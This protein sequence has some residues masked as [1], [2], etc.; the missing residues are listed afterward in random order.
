MSALLGWAALTLAGA[1]CETRRDSAVT[2]AAATVASIPYRGYVLGVRAGDSEEVWE[3]PREFCSAVYATSAA[4]AAKVNGSPDA[5]EVADRAKDPPGL[6]YIH[7]GTRVDVV[8][9]E[10]RTC[11][12]TTTPI[13]WTRLRIRDVS[14]SLDGCTFYFRAGH[15]EKVGGDSNAGLVHRIAL[16]RTKASVSRAKGGDMPD[17]LILKGG[18]HVRIDI[19]SWPGTAEVAAVTRTLSGYKHS[20]DE[21]PDSLDLPI[22]VDATIDGIVGQAHFGD[23]YVKIHGANWSGFTR[24]DRMM[25]MVPVG[26]KLI[27]AGGAPPL[28]PNLDADDAHSLRT[29]SGTSFREI[30]PLSFASGD[31]DRTTATG[32][33]KVQ[34]LDGEYAGRVGWVSSIGLPGL[35]P[36]TFPECRCVLVEMYAEQQARGFHRTL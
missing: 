14:S 6:H 17:W 31:P 8:G 5:D 21:A 10:S 16:S 27:A 4:F 18:A 34:V 29:E 30:A 26:T 3:D 22:G 7:P 15:L 32:R 28:Y 1:G 2:H 13:G 12:L 11:P 36:A 25:P 33:Y 35:A 23:Y 20:A 19:A 9:H 24:S